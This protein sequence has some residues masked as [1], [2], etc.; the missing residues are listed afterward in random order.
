MSTAETRFLDYVGDSACVAGGVQLATASNNSV[1][2]TASVSF[3]GQSASTSAADTQSNDSDSSS[4]DAWQAI[5]ISIPVIVLL[6]LPS[7]FI[8]WRLRKYRKKG[9]E[10]PKT[11]ELEGQELS[12]GGEMEGQGRN[13]KLDGEALNEAEVNGPAQELE[14]VWIQELDSS[15]A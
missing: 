10:V 4:T 14:S 15:K 12:R 1:I 5:R 6:A 2:G 11:S 8:W 9:N 3:A 13:P 7:V